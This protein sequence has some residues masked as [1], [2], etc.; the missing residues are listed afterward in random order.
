MHVILTT[1]QDKA[2]ELIAKK[3]ELPIAQ[4][5]RRAIDMYLRKLVET[6]TKK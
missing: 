1:Q 5:V 4:H 3:T 2:L 6:P